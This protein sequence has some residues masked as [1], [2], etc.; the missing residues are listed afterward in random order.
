[1]AK[2]FKHFTSYYREITRKTEM[3]QGTAITGNPSFNLLERSVRLSDINQATWRTVPYF[4]SRR[5][6]YKPTNRKR[7][8]LVITRKARANAEHLID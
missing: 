2:A 5:G 7:P 1:M 8:L 6:P 3:N 4:K